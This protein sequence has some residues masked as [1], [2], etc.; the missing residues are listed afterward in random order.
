MDNNIS[1]N[2]SEAMVYKPL[3]HHKLKSDLQI[4]EDKCRLK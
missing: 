2:H 4:S 1:G 3:E